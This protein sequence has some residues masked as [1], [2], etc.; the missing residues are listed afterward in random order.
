MEQL[1]A[2]YS[3]LTAVERGDGFMPA[4][5]INCSAGRLGSVQQLAAV[6]DGCVGP[7]RLEAS[8][9]RGYQASWRAVLT[10]GIA[11]EC[12]ASLLPRSKTVI[13]ALSQELLTVGCSPGTIRNIWSS[14]EDRHRRFGQSLPLGGSLGTFG[15]CTRQWLRCAGHLRVSFS[16][17]STSSE[18][19]V[20]AHWARPGAVARCAGGSYGNGPQLPGG[21]GGFLVDSDLRFPVGHGC[22]FP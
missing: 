21:R 17:G 7:A 5:R 22:G 15:A 12:V 11:H 9:R 1:L 4:V 2:Y 16:N 18:V 6:F 19:D 20:G 14:I 13:K 3:E 10:W 8:T